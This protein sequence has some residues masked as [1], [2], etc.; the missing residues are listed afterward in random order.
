[1]EQ[2]SDEFF[3]ED[4]MSDASFQMQDKLEREA[5]SLIQKRLQAV[6]LGS[7]PASLHSDADSGA[8]SDVPYL[9]SGAQPT[10]SEGRGLNLAGSAWNIK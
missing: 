6:S 9:A 8:D 3:N 2:H 10:A 1:M 4:N 7:P 5:A